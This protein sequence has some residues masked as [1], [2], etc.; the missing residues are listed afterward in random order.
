MGSYALEKPQ[1]DWHRGQVLQNGTKYYWKNA[2]NVQWEITPL[3]TE[4]ILRNDSPTRYPGKHFI[5]KL[6]VDSKGDYTNVVEG[7]M[8]DRAFYKRQ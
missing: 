5:I 7:L 4:G 6:K 8:F 3:P 2:A 1:N